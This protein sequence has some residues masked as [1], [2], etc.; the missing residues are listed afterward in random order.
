MVFNLAKDVELATGGLV[1]T[2]RAVTT[3]RDRTRKVLRALWKGV[4]YMQT[5]H[6]GT[7]DLMQKRLPKT[8]RETLASDLAAALEDVTEDGSLPLASARSE[9]AVR[10]EILGI[11]PDKILPPDKVYDFSLVKEVVAEL[12]RTG[13]RPEK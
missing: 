5:Q 7:I 11:P 6:E 9:L 10:G 4:V 12:K 8:P 2:E 13:F 1:A 3:D